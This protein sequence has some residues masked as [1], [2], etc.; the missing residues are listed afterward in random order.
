[1][2]GLSTLI[3]YALIAFAIW[4]LYKGVRRLLFG[5]PK[6]PRTAPWPGPFA[7]GRPE[8]AEVMDEMVQDPA[9]GVYV[10]RQQAVRARIKGKVHY[11]CSDECR[12]KFLNGQRHQ[13]NNG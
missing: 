5:P 4:L 9:C 11:F 1:M 10:P 6:R 13:E 7:R 2:L 8:N 12:Q 3:R